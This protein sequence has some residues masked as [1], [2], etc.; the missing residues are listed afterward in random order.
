LPASSSSEIGAHLESCSQC[1]DRLDELHSTL[2]ALVVA[3]R[4]A[5]DAELPATN[6][7][8]VRLQ[9]RLAELAAQEQQQGWL[10]SAWIS[11][12]DQRSSLVIA[13]AVL[14]ACLLIAMRLHG[15]FD[16]SQPMPTALANWEEPNLRLTPGA[17]VPVTENQLCGTAPQETDPAVPVSLKRKVF[18]LYGVTR[19]HP[20]AYDVDYLITP[21]L[22]G[23]T[24]IRN[25]WPE[26]NQDTVWN[27]HVKDQLEARLHRM[28][29]HGD[30]DLATAQRDISTDWIAAYRKYFHADRPVADDSSSNFPE[31]RRTLPLT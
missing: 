5:R 18:D 13:G 31:V 17:V 29:C 15:P 30:V 28:V 2:A 10:R 3:H 26:P 1:R 24:D 9:A 19:S 21:E 27:A 16:R 20:D 23:A 11:L 14:A 4:N 25:L 6:E 22:G 7:P 8:L 12:A